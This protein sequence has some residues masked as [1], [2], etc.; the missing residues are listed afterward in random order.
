LY[1]TVPN[2]CET[3]EFFIDIMEVSGAKH[4]YRLA[5]ILPLISQDNVSG[6]Q[7]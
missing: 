1:K 5:G 3:A 6:Y 4:D 2:G 7:V